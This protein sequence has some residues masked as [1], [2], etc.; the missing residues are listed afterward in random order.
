[1]TNGTGRVSRARVRV[2]MT[3][4]HSGSAGAPGSLVRSNTA[5]DR[6]VSGRAARNASVGKGRNRRTISAPTFSPASIIASTA[7]MA[8]P[9]PEPISTTTRVASAAPT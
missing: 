7:S 3:S 6:T 8:A 2:V 5:I 9:A 4:W 1:M